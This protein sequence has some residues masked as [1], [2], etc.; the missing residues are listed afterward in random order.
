MALLWSRPPP[1][2]IPDVESDYIRLVTVNHVTNF[3]TGVEM[4]NL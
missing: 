1:Q 3:N 2:T 4:Q